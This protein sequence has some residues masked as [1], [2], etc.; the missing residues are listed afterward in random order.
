MNHLRN[1]RS[2]PT[3]SSCW[4]NLQAVVRLR[5]ALK[6]EDHGT[7]KDLLAKHPNLA[8][9]QSD[10]QNVLSSDVLN[11]LD[12]ALPMKINWDTFYT[13]GVR[14]P[15]FFQNKP[16]AN[17]VR[18]F[19]SGKLIPGKA[20]DLGCGMGRNAIYMT[21]QGC[22]VD[23]IDLSRAAISVATER[24]GESGHRI[25]FDAQNFLFADMPSGTYDI[26][27]DSGLLHH[28]QPHRRSDYLAKVHSVLKPKGRFALLCFSD[29]EAPSADDQ[30]IYQ[31]AKMPPGIGYSKSRILEVVE[32]TFRVDEII[33]TDTEPEESE[34]LSLTGLWA[35]LARPRS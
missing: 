2:S 17:L 12:A 6:S 5:D 33:R 34:S 19:E 31:T 24:A 20:L 8:Q 11:A 22:E 23:G 29:S 18:Y 27:Y 15:P 10:R 13:D 1:R 30:D 26:V 28:L 25:R 3:L 14:T 9:G 16:D 4:P 21:Q 7:V 35:I 32:P